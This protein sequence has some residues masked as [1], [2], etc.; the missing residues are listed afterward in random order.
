MA[1]AGVS[2][3][4]DILHALGPTEVIGILAIL[5]GVGYYVINYTRF[6]TTIKALFDPLGAAKN[7]LD[8]IK[9]KLNDLEDRAKVAEEATAAKVKELADKGK[10][11]A[12]ALASK[13]RQEAI[14][15]GNKAKQ[16]ARD[17]AA[18]A[19]QEEQALAAKIEEDAHK[20]ESWIVHESEDIRGR[21]SNEWHNLFG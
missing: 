3:T 19:K 6:G 8:E 15:A 2:V 5:G 12:T 10:A 4:S 21:I 20:A 18:K 16:E 1:T 17:F 13:A 11:E 9:G 14:N 7:T